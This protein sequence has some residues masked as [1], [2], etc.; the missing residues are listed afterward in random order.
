MW[1]K[2]SLT[3][4]VAGLRRR[5]NDLDLDRQFV[6]AG[7]LVALLSMAAIGTWV[8]SRVRSDSIANEA[9]NTAKF[10]DSFIAPLAQELQSSDTFSIGPIRALDEVLDTAEL[11]ERV[12]SVKIWKPSGRIA[13]ARD[14]NL[15]GQSFPLSPGLTG[16]LAGKTVAEFNELDE[17]ESRDEQ[18]TGIPLLEIYSPIRADWTGDIIGVA[19]FYEN[20]TELSAQLDRAR[21]QGWLL[22]AGVTS[23]IC[24][25]LF[26]IVHRGSRTIMS[27][28]QAL[29]P[30]LTE[31]ERAA[32]QNADLRR[33]VERASRRLSELSEANLRRM[34]SDLH[35]GPAQLISL[36]ALKLDGWR[37]L[38]GKAQAAAHEEI[39][40]TV[41][42]ALAELRQISRGLVLPEL[43]QLELGE[44]IERAIAAH[45]GR[46]RKPVR[47]EIALLDCDAP[48]ATKI[49]VYRF[50]QEGLNNAFRHAAGQDQA[51]A[52]SI[53]DGKLMVRV[54]NKVDRN[55]ATAETASEKLGLS[56]LRD[57]VESLGG[58]FSFGLV[59]GQAV[60]DMQVNVTPGAG[61]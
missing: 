35:D 23:L 7:G 10:M 19:E 28:R 56:G 17:D 45:E 51:V 29:A 33:Q 60:L 54:T 57:R 20:A 55:H 39:S 43:A 59:G 4:W 40:R 48:E 6:I 50:V 30:R 47:R 38:S 15:I 9:A 41:Q 22:T 32:Q 36:V 42:T 11:R 26:G 16:A 24:L 21:L 31:V 14:V 3:D 61:A 2:T 25:S 37:K 53:V 27:Q 46:T 34:G 12:V 5:F 52:A 49:C 13:Y 58:R 44:V 1:P 8:A 18:K